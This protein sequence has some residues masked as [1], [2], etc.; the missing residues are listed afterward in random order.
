MADRLDDLLHDYFTGKLNVDINIRKLELQ[1]NSNR[2]PD[3]NVGGGRKQND[4]NYPVENRMIREQNDEYLQAML[5]Q[6]TVI[7]MMLGVTIESR[8]RV[9]NARYGQGKSWIEIGLDEHVDERT[10][11][12][13]R[14]DF[15]SGLG[16][17]LASSVETTTRFCS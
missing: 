7:E 3:E 4:F 16:H 5:Y 8:K 15:K 1:F 14:D 10:V 6:K 11:R 13:W 9:L 17:W 12:E 2:T